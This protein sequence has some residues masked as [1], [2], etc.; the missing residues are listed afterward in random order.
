MIPLFAKVFAACQAAGLSVVVTVSHSAPY[1]TDTPQDSISFMEAW[2]ADSN[3]NAISPQ[4][5]SGGEEKSPEFAETATCKN[6]GCT[7]SL[8]NNSVPKFV[9]SIVD[10]GQYAAVQNYFKKKNIKCD[11]F[12]QWKQGT[13]VASQSPFL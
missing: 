10:A 7:W 1:E 4:L 11:G 8:Y 2:L 9:P 13:S 3:I 12:F 6:A 5:Y